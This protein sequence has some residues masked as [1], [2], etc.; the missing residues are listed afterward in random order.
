M[1]IAEKLQTIAEKQQN[2]YDA[3]Y[4]KGH[5]NGE[6]VGLDRGYV[7]GVN[8][9]RNITWNAIQINGVRTNYER[10]FLNWNLEGIRPLH[11]MR[12]TT[13]DQMF[14][15]TKGVHTDLAKVF[16]DCGVTL[17]TS[18]S[19]YFGWMFYTSHVTRVPKIDA[20]SVTVLD[21][22]F[23]AAQYL[24]TI[25]ELVVKDG[26]TFKDT[27]Q[28]CTSLKN[29]K[30]TGVISTDFNISSAPLTLESAISVCRALL[31]MA[32]QYVCTVKFSS[33]VVET[34]ANTAY[35][36]TGAI[37]GNANGMTWVQYIDAIGWN[38]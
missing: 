30:V 15:A 1:N 6:M 7:D 12:P 16:E 11:D 28:G 21:S 27:F 36:G 29:L 18:N 23:Y 8:E 25:D 3:G 20:T 22:T 17:D 31:S 19:K 14:R 13:S 26:L 35:D 37:I 34:L 5:F 2:V 33:D 38:T 32:D 10:A 4:N 9:E 24:E